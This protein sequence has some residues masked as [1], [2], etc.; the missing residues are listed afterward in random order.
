M[1]MSSYVTSKAKPSGAK[2]RDVV[3]QL[4]DKFTKGEDFIKRTDDYDRL[5]SSISAEAI[6]RK[7]YTDRGYEF[8]QPYSDHASIAIKEAINDSPKLMAIKQQDKIDTYIT[9]AKD[10]NSLQNVPDFRNSLFLNG[11]KFSEGEVIPNKLIINPV[12]GLDPFVSLWIMNIGT[13]SALAATDEDIFK[14]FQRIITDPK[15]PKHLKSFRPEAL[16]KEILE[17]QLSSVQDIQTFLVAKGADPDVAADVAVKCAGKLQSLQ[18]LADIHLYSISG[19]GYTAKDILTIEKVVELGFPFDSP[20][21][22]RSFLLNIGY[23]YMRTRPLYDQNRTYIQRRKVKI[24]ANPEYI[25]SW[26]KTI[27]SDSTIIGGVL[28]SFYQI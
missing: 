9:M 19:E 8:R 22:F 1:V 23:Q 20:S 11:L 2:M 17:K 27:S 16:V 28:S 12:A 24:E 10:M 5:K 3:S 7:V 25:Q 6:I 4:K 18:F 21:P 15:Y 14:S 13:S 26:L